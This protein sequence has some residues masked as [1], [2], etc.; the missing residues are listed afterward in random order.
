MI[1]ESCR[2]HEDFDPITLVIFHSNAAV[3]V[4]Y[5]TLMSISHVLMA[6]FSYKMVLSETRTTDTRR[7]NLKFFAAQIQIPLPNIWYLDMKT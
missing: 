4:A 2:P 5:R 1:I 3:P 6:D 7:L